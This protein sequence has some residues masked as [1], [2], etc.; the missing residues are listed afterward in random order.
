MLLAVWERWVA[1]TGVLPIVS[2]R[3]LPVP[4]TVTFS[5]NVTVKSRLLP[6]AYVPLFGGVIV[7]VTA[8]ATPSTRTPAVAPTLLSVRSAGLPAP[9]WIV[10]VPRDS[11]LIVMPLASR[12]PACTV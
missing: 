10:L 7:P 11:P 2:A 5:S 8:G 9:S 3:V 1:K 6:A 12:S 4:V